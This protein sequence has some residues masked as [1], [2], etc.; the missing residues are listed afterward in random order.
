M[1]G[2]RRAAAL[3]LAI[4]L[5]AGGA[6]AGEA[7]TGIL[8]PYFRIQTQLTE[9]RMDTVKADT[10]EIAKAAAGLGAPAASIA[11]AAKELSGAA[12]I[13]AA[14][15]AFGKLSTAVIAYAEST[16]ASIGANTA[17]V[18][19]SMANKSWLQKGNAVKNPYYGKAMLTCGEIKKKA[20]V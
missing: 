12:D 9:D 19:C 16:K 15:E 18:Y 11:G 6:L 17:T 7:L 5:F 2:L 20:G 1:N 14:R 13:D 8:D 3:G 10:S 4:G